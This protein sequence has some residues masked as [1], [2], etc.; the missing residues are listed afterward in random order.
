MRCNGWTDLA[1]ASRGAGLQR[2]GRRLRQG[3]GG[4]GVSRRAD[5][6]SQQQGHHGEAFQNAH[7]D[8]TVDS[9]HQRAPTALN[10]PSMS[11]EHQVAG[12]GQRAAPDP[13]LGVRAAT[14]AGFRF[15][16][17]IASIALSSSQPT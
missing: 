12:A 13:L 10:Q 17:A 3:G 15:I 9:A 2:V 8:K 4:Q 11:V 5:R 16:Q 1:G 14:A 6:A 7:H